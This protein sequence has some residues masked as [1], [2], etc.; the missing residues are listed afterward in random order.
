ML[1]SVQVEH[2]GDG[3]LQFVLTP[4]HL[5]ILENQRATREILC[6]LKNSYSQCRQ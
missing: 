2:S 5:A 3:K 1:L 6:I 4:I